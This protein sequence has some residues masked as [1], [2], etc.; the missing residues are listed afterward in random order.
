MQPRFEVKIS[1]QSAE[2]ILDDK[3]LLSFLANMKAS[4]TDDESADLKRQFK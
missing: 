4:A 1:S 3:N 2:N